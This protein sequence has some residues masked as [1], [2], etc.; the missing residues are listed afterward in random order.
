MSTVK[1]PNHSP[2]HNVKVCRSHCQS[3]TLPGQTENPEFVSAFYFLRTK[4]IIVL[5]PFSLPNSGAKLEFGRLKGLSTLIALVP[6][7]S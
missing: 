5:R 4:A 1:K 7:C 2:C 6:K 3:R